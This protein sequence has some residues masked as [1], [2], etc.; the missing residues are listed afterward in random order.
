MSMFT[1]RARFLA[2]GI[3]AGLVCVAR[4][5]LPDDPGL[6]FAVLTQR[7]WTDPRSGHWIY[8]VGVVGDPLGRPRKGDLLM[9]SPPLSRR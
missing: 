3:S 6:R 9:L 7:T 5:G 1:Y 8:R 2:Y 4:S